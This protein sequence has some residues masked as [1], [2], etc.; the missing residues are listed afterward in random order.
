[1]QK[2]FNG[3]KI[4]VQK[5]FNDCAKAIGA[6]QLLLGLL[7]AFL[8]GGVIGAWGYHQ[9][10]YHFTIPVAALLFWFGFGSVGYDVRIRV[11]AYLK[12][13]KKS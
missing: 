9:V 2:L 5:L 7:A 8:L 10:A 13:H 6:L 3:S 4:F 1:M 11:R 12:Q